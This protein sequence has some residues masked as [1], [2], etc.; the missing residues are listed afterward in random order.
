LA[1]VHESLAEQA[2]AM[3]ADRGSM[4]EGDVA[5]D[6]DGTTVEVRYPIYLDGLNRQTFLLAIRDITGMADSLAEI[7]GAA[8]AAAAE[9]PA[10]DPEDVIEAE[11]AIVAPATEPA[12]AAA[13][14]E[15]I[16]VDEAA[17]WVATHTVPG[18]G[19]PA[20]AEPDPGLAPVANLS[21]RVELQVNEQRGAWARVTGS[22]G[23]TGW[24]DAR[25]LRQLGSASA[26]G[27]TPA[28]TAPVTAAATTAMAGS[29]TVRPLT[30]LGGLAMV[31][32]SLPLL[33]WL[34]PLEVDSWDVG[35]GWLWQG[36]L[37]TP[38]LGLIMVLLGIAAIVLAI[39]PRVPSGALAAVSGVGLTVTAVFVLHVIRLD[40][41]ADGQIEVLWDGGVGI[42]WW[43]SLLG[44]GLTAIP[45]RLKL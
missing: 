41:L 20:W 11:E 39:L 33:K 22:N 14:A 10:S 7:G 2:K 23:W 44:A 9:E 8:Q 29:L 6:K 40:W 35:L 16:V 24:V 30:L 18:G 13:A 28:G 4:I 25:K 36:S 37:S 42:G 21:A 26:A 38:R 17:A 3:L 12:A 45:Y 1:G 19:I 27:V 34:P 32:G 5:G 43:A 31:L 15:T